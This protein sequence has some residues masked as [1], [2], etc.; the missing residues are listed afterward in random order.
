VIELSGFMPEDVKAGVAHI[1]DEKQ[2][3]KLT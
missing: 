2:V 1:F 3:Q